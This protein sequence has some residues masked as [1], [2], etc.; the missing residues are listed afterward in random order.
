M[1][2]PPRRHNHVGSSSSCTL[3]AALSQVEIAKNSDQINGYQCNRIWCVALA[4]SRYLGRCRL[5]SAS[6]QFSCKV[7][8]S[9]PY[10]RWL[11]SMGLLLVWTR[12]YQMRMLLT[13]ASS[14]RHCWLLAPCFRST[15]SC[16]SDLNRTVYSRVEAGQSPATDGAAFH[17][18]SIL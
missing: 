18:P 3:M 8:F 16:A 1:S 11:F 6:Y 5:A 12:F 4:R 13:S 2:T 10:L 14:T 9:M 17:T 7:P 15:S